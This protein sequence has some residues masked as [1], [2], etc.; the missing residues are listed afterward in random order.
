M[1]AQQMTC[2][3]EAHNREAIIE[4]LDTHVDLPYEQWLLEAARSPH[5]LMRGDAFRALENRSCP[6]GLAQIAFD[7]LD[8]EVPYVRSTAAAALARCRDPRAAPVLVELLDS[9]EDSTR[10]EAIIALSF[11][12]ETTL[13]YDPFADLESRLEAIGR[14]ER[15]LE[16]AR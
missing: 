5:P 15:W 1:L 13:G 4:Y 12:S 14:F 8:S 6:E 7:A 16:D 9:P 3:S 2:F 10:S 11:L